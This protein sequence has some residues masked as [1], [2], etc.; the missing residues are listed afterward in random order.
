MKQ[1]AKLYQRISCGMGDFA[2][3]ALY[4]RRW[5]VFCLHLRHWPV[6]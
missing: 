2:K 1:E 5:L 4:N 3:A 6:G